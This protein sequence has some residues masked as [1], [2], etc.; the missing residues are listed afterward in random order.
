MPK[1]YIKGRSQKKDPCHDKID[2]NSLT[3]WFK[4]KLV[5]VVVQMRS[6][7]REGYS[8]ICVHPTTFQFS[9]IY[10]LFLLLTHLGVIFFYSLHIVKKKKKKEYQFSTLTCDVRSLP[11][12]HVRVDMKNVEVTVHMFCSTSLANDALV[13]Y[14]IS[15]A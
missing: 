7:L 4:Y 9:G 13:I 1:D 8:L 10:V 14:G 12:I 15:F 11:P 6:P 3:S 2:P 5:N